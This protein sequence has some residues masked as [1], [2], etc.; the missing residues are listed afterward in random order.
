MD[1]DLTRLKDFHGHLG[2]FA[3]LGYRMGQVA[4]RILGTEPFGK[5]AR[6]LTGTAPPVSCLI[7]GVQ[8]SSGCTLG[9]G[10]MEVEDVSGAQV[11]FTDNDGKYITVAVKQHI[12][13]RINDE[14][15]KENEEALAAELYSLGDD[16]LFDIDESQQ[17]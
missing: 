5:S 13:D 12:L 17:R 10:N 11:I 14:C 2:P 6:A 16:E 15:S 3:A 4:N 7:D 8:L 9:K 1:E